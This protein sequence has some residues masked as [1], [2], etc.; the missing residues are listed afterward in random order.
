MA[1]KYFKVKQPE[2]KTRQQTLDG[3]TLEDYEVRGL[4]G[5]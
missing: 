5:D 2:P 3:A 1:T 4:R